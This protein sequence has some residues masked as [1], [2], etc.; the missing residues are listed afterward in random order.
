MT[1]KEFMDDYGYYVY[2]IVFISVWSGWNLWSG[3]N[4]RECRIKMIEAG[5]TT[6]Q[7]VKLCE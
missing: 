7:A 1:L 4:E 3:Y 5:K 6:E 2:L